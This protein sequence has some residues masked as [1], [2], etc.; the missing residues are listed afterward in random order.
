MDIDNKESTKNTFL[1][2][3]LDKSIFNELSPSRKFIT[4]IGSVVGELHII[5][6]GSNKQSLLKI[7]DNIWIYSVRYIPFFSFIKVHKIIQSQLIWKRHFKPIAIISMGDEIMIAKKFAKKYHRSLYVFYSYMKLLGNKEIS[8]SKLVHSSPT[9]I[10]IPNT[11]ISNVIKNHSSY[12]AKETE[13]IIF[14]EYIDILELDNIF[15]SNNLIEYNN[16]NSKNKI[17]TMII[18]SEMVGINLFKMIRTISKEIIPFILKFRFS[19]IVPDNQFLKARILRYLFGI[20]LEILKENEDSINLFHKSH[21]MLYFGKSDIYYKPILYSF[22]AGCPVISSGDEYSKIVL[23]NSDFEKYNHLSKD[24]K[25]FGLVIK[26]MIND[27]YLYTK[28][29]INCVDMAKITFT[30]DHNIYIKEL[31]DNLNL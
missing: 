4:D 15:N 12:Q 3:T 31:S 27:P 25:T 23:F 24:G 17:F 26:N 13:V 21:I 22:I 1:M 28:Y 10:F 11:Y 18:F 14:S 5:Y 9:K 29:K 20:S 6:I 30:Q 16:S 2:I 19:L 8:L 7:S